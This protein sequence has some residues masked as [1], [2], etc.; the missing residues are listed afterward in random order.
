MEIDY[1]PEAEKFPKKVGPPGKGVVIF[2][3]GKPSSWVNELR[4]PDHWE[5]GCIAIDEHGR[6]WKTVGGNNQ[7][8]ARTWQPCFLKVAVG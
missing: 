1:N 3:G 4:S 6:Q 2:F 7:D 8:G 5:P